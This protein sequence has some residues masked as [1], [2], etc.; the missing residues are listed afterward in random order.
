MRRHDPLAYDARHGLPHVGA[1]HGAKVSDEEPDRERGQVEASL[2]VAVNVLR[3]GGVDG[4]VGKEDEEEAQ[5]R[6]ERHL[7]HA[8][9]GAEEEKKMFDDEMDP[10]KEEVCIEV[11][12]RMYPYSRTLSTC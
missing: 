8:E 3:R 5:R 12:R 10:A 6:E 7:E 11:V 1:E 4:A 2:D 9:E